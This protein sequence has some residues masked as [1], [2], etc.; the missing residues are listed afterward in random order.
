MFYYKE[1]AKW[2]AEN[3]ENVRRDCEDNGCV[4]HDEMISFKAPKESWEALVSEV[5]EI[6]SN[7]T[8]VT[9]DITT[10]PR[11][12]IWSICNILIQKG[13]QI[14]YV[15]FKP[16]ENGYGTW[17]SREPGRPRILYRLGGIQHLGWPTAL[18][19]QTGYDI[20]RVK[21][22]IRFYEPE[23]VLLAV[24]TGDQLGNIEANKNKHQKAFGQDRDV[25]MFDFDGYSLLDASDRL[26]D[27][28]KPLAQEYNVI[29]SSL[30]PKV[31]SLA[32]FIVKQRIPEV[33]LAYAPSNEFNREY[34][35]GIGNCVHGI[36][37]AE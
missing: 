6:V 30:G 33:A 15:Y 31:G 5:K 10:M 18:V 37:K 13:I 1:Y 17:L 20:E 25:E 11:E 36:L 14:Q 8:I 7:D 16:E 29:L 35:K 24:Q 23:K 22:L 32:L 34:S 28:V 21:Q 12:A 26:F 4:L 9:L 19:V 2:S 3:R 27:K